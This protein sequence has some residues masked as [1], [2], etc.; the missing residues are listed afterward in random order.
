MVLVSAINDKSTMETQPNNSNPSTRVAALDDKSFIYN[1]RVLKLLMDNTA[2][3]IQRQAE[4]KQYLDIMY[5]CVQAFDLCIMVVQLT[6]LVERDASSPEMRARS[7]YPMPWDEVRLFAAEI[8]KYMRWLVSMFENYRALHVINGVRA[9]VD[10]TDTDA[11]DS[12][13][14][15]RSLAG[16]TASDRI[17]T[18]DSAVSRPPV[19]VTVVRQVAVDSLL[20]ELSATATDAHVTPPP[21]IIDQLRTVA[22]LEAGVSAAAAGGGAASAMRDRIGSSGSKYIAAFM[23]PGDAEAAKQLMR[24]F[25]AYLRHR[26]ASHARTADR[27]TGPNVTVRLYEVDYARL[28]SKYTGQSELNFETMM[29]WFLDTVKHVNANADARNSIVFNVLAFRDADV[30]LGPRTSGDPDHIASM[31]NAMLQFMDEFNKN[32]DLRYFAIVFTTGGRPN[33]LDEAFARRVENTVLFE[34]ADLELMSRSVFDQLAASHA[35]N[36]TEHMR[37]SLAVYTSYADML[38]RVVDV[39]INVTSAITNDFITYRIDEYN[40]LVTDN[41]TGSRA[42]RDP[43]AR[44]V[45]NLKRE[46][47]N[48]DRIE[49]VCTNMV[50]PIGGGGTRDRY[51]P[52]RVQDERT[53]SDAIASVSAFVWNGP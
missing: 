42:L 40:A 32:T 38:R 13:D 53:L 31:K 35:L 29:N 26:L 4:A 16:L 41:G 5:V 6:T 27:Q 25:V 17:V 12:I 47:V 33:A 46:R 10:R 50:E 44:P 2:L 19:A 36:V 8:E 34:R 48:Y 22:L 24:S 43:G 30:L 51:D 37:D 1:A 3:F 23:A 18:S 20:Y 52:S 49:Y 11:A 39:E 21:P 7:V 45:F 28:L 15:M 14:L 9:A